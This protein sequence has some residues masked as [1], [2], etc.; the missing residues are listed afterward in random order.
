MPAS[1]SVVEKEHS[2]FPV[3]V[4][5]GKCVPSATRQARWQICSVPFPQKL[6]TQ[7]QDVHFPRVCVPWEPPLPMARYL[8]LRVWEFVSFFACDTCLLCI[9]I[10]N[11]KW[12]NFLGKG[13]LPSHSPRYWASDCFCFAWKSPLLLFF[14]FIFVLS[15]L[16]V[17]RTRCFASP[18]FQPNKLFAIQK[19]KIKKCLETIQSKSLV[20]KI[21]LKCFLEHHASCLNIPPLN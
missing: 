3:E 5:T 10:K 17:F 21:K 12:R 4:F 19:I 14:S 16:S 13:S 15:L 6:A 7:S 8:C 11:R 2:G 1:G 20:F 18:W 9:C